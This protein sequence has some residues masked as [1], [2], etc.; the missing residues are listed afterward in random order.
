MNIKLT[1]SVICLSL[2]LQFP[3]S[4]KARE[5]SYT[6]HFNGFRYDKI[7]VTDALSSFLGVES[8]DQSNQLT[9]G[10]EQFEA[11][12]QQTYSLAFDILD[13]TFINRVGIEFKQDLGK[14]V[15]LNVS[16]SHGRGS[17]KYGFPDGLSILSDPAIM[18]SRFSENL[19]S[20]SLEKQIFLSEKTYIFCKA[21]SNFAA[22][23]I[24]THITSALLNV[25]SSKT[26]HITYP[27]YTLGVRFVD[28]LSV[29]P[30][31]SFDNL[32]DPRNSISIS[33]S[34]SQSF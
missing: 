11:S 2:F 26:H 4:C 5:L 18:Y 29:S 7:A 28:G 20:L 33:L 1:Y 15:T 14:N 17:G 8:E 12:I 30:S 31:I 25:R 6:L 9:L 34:I 10:S 16:L 24:D 32:K 22:V 23:D 21:G 13:L 27:D 19:L 3:N